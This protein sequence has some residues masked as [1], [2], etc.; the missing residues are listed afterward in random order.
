MLI[1]AG[2]GGGTS[3]L[4]FTITQFL[5]LSVALFLIKHNSWVFGKK[6]G[7]IYFTSAVK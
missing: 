2:G 7:Y 4:T 5:K 6:E 1:L 3:M